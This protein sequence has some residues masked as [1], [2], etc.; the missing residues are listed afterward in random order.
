[1]W[2][3][4]PS[5]P[6]KPSWKWTLTVSYPFLPVLFLIMYIVRSDNILFD[7]SV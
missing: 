2:V 5:R 1:M 3:S 6:R 4:F 7:I